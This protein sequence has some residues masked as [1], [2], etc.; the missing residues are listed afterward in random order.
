M[1]TSESLSSSLEMATIAANTAAI[2]AKEVVA[3]ANGSWL[4]LIGRIILFIIQVLSTILYWSLKL[5]TIS[6]PTLLFQ[7]F[8]TSL[9]V[10]M[11]ATTL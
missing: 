9:T 1:A 10:T 7:L 11:N 4:G 2:Q 6:V 3:A 8:S 5:T